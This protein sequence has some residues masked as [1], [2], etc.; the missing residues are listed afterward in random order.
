LYRA[1]TSR[2]LQL[3]RA[4]GLIAKVPHL[5]K[6]EKDKGKKDKKEKKDKK[7]KDK[8]D[9][10]GKDKKAKDNDSDD[11]VDAPPKKDKGKDKN[12]KKLLAREEVRRV[13]GILP[14]ICAESKAAPGAAGCRPEAHLSQ[15]GDGRLGCPLL[16]GK[17]SPLSA[18]W[19]YQSRFG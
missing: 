11:D 8:K 19:N 15:K 6:A 9:K 2:L 12:E 17:G 16:A 10:K 5:V 13:I 18:I 4:H 1:L 14:R 7:G 3:L